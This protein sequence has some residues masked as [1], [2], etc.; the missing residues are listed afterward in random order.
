MQDA[1]S[2]SGGAA[3]DSG[4]GGVLDAAAAAAT[5]TGGGV[6]MP[7]VHTHLTERFRGKFQRLEFPTFE[8]M[9][10]EDAMNNC[11]VRS[12]IACVGGAVL[13]VAFGIFMGSVDTGVRG[14]WAGSAAGRRRSRQHH[15]EWHGRQQQRGAPPSAHSRARAPALTHNL[16][17]TPS[18]L[19]RP[20]R[21]RGRPGHRL[22]G[23]WGKQAHARRA[24]GDP[25]AHADKERVSGRAR[26]R[27]RARARQ[28]SGP[29]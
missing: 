22:A 8:Q 29:P 27:A 1:P 18:P 7:Y 17:F 6:D 16:T 24:A 11:G 15:S 21:R 4:S 23:A 13:G 12:V 10:A 9:M 5:D 20:R 3:A 28:C 14:A 2:T 19:L 26:A 25:H